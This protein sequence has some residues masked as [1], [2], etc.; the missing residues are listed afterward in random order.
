MIKKIV[1]LAILQ[2]FDW[3]NRYILY[4]YICMDGYDSL[5]H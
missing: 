2:T 3:L 4:Y 5:G 1:K